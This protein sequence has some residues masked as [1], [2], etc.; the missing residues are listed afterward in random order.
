MK[1]GE[2]SLEPST[3]SQL[4]FP[5]RIAS[6]Q[7]PRKFCPGWP[8]SVHQQ[9]SQLTNQQSTQRGNH[10]GLISGPRPPGPSW[11]GAIIGNGR[12]RGRGLRRA[13]SG[14]SEFIERE[15]QGLQRFDVC[16]V[17]ILRLLDRDGGHPAHGA[18]EVVEVVLRLVVS[19]DDHQL[20]F[21]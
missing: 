15:E 3:D 4:E 20:V 13:G 1:K 19:D 12:S 10:A 2:P 17:E 6:C 14:R 11:A 18:V 7:H 9:A 21:F 8:G 5:F 16:R